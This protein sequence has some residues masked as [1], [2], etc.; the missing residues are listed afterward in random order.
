M[1][2]RSRDV[3]TGFKRPGK[4]KTRRKQRRQRQAKTESLFEKMQKDLK[5]RELP[6]YG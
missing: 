6:A 4:K 5:P 1:W 3:G 2:E